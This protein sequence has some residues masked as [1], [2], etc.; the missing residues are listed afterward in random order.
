M[1]DSTTSTTFQEQRLDVNGIDTA[2]LTAGTGDP[3]VFLHGAGTA[4]GFDWL[5]PL[6]EH[7]HVIVPNHPGFGASGDP[8]LAGPDHLARHTL[9]VIDRLGVDRFTLVGQSMGGWTAAT[10]ATWRADRL[11]KLV[12][13][14][15][16]GLDVPEHPTVDL[17]AVAPQ[18]LPGYLTVKVAEIFGPPD[19]PPPPPEFLAARQREGASFATMTSRGAPHE[20]GLAQWLHRITVPTL[21]LWGTADALVPVGQAAVWA[22]GIPN[23][24]VHTIDGAGHLLF[25]ERGTEATDPIIDFARS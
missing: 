9:D 12:L 24:R 16:V 22:A 15:P 23:A 11:H 19:A 5:L 3:L 1:S 6:A 25:E 18:D 4:S 14:A 17:A 2:V 8:A 21:V 20:T 13:V 7:F 10:L